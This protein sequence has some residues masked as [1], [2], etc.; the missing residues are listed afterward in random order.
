MMIANA[1]LATEAAPAAATAPGSGTA[2]TAGEGGGLFQQL[3]QG[4]QPAGFWEKGAAATAVP[5]AQPESGATKKEVAEQMSAANL[6]LPETAQE[7]SVANPTGQRSAT[8]GARLQ[9]VMTWQALKSD[10]AAKP[11]QGTAPAGAETAAAEVATAEVATAEV[12]TAGKILPEMETV[13]TDGER[14]EEAPVQAAS[15]KPAGQE[16]AAAAATQPAPKAAAVEQGA[17]PRGLEV[18]AGKVE[19]ARERRGTEAQVAAGANALTQLDELQQKALERQAVERPEA[20]IAAAQAEKAV[21]P[22]AGQPQQPASTKLGQKAEQAELP[23]QKGEAVASGAT[24]AARMEES[25]PAQPGAKGAAA[26]FVATPVNGSVRESLTQTAPEAAQQA[27]HADEAADAN[28]EQQKAAGNPGTAEVT[29]QAAPKAKAQGEV[30]HPQQQGATP[31][32]PRPEAAQ[33]TERT[34]QRRD[35]QHGDEKHVPVQGADN[36][37]QPEAASAAA[38]DLTGTKGAPVVSAAITPEQLRG[39]EGSQFKQ[40][41]HQQQGQES[42]NAQLQGAAVGAQGSMAETA[43]PESHQTATRSALHEHILSQV[44][45]G[46]V[47]HD[48][49]GNGQMSIRLNPGE[50]GELKIQV[51]MEHNRLKVEVQADNRMVKDLLMSNLDSLKEALSGK[52]LAMDGFNVSTGSGGFQQPLYEER[53]NQR[54][55]S[56]SRFARG[57]GYDAPQ[58]TRVNYLTAEVNNLLDVR[59]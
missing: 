53:A 19:A 45:D 43:A 48:G 58:E 28:K 33:A 57:G 10:L 11:E 12:A 40:Q 22:E 51:S 35:L 4:K 30:I 7:G 34:A 36:A 24:E 13:T 1:T 2:A 54:Q 21:L 52:D 16:M 18:A 27:I 17:V 38:K 37:G 29:A 15:P 47:T 44:K 55:Q 32:A 25:N 8:G 59:F 46:V 41:G 31:E 56:A 6:V 49:K 14:D 50:L 5:A 3:L 39:A 42:Q 20:Q 9:L 26:G 23:Q